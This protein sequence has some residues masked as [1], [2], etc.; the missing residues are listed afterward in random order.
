MVFQHSTHGLADK[1]L[2]SDV[3]TRLHV[4]YNL[5]TCNMPGYKK[6]QTLHDGGWPF[7]ISRLAGLANWPYYAL[8]DTDGSKLCHKRGWNGSKQRRCN[9]MLFSL[10]SARYLTSGLY[11]FQKSLLAL[12]APR[13]LGYHEWQRML[14]KDH[15]SNQDVVWKN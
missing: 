8:T 7:W 5:G 9:Y 15:H 11:T 13:H 10:I 6:T 3:F 1:C 4:Q 12:E 14:A 2:I